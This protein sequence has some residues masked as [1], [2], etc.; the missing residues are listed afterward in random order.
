M[1]VA[2][3]MLVL[4]EE[5]Y[6]DHIICRRRVL[7]SALGLCIRRS[8]LSLATRSHEGNRGIRDLTRCPI[9]AELI[10]PPLG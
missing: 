2:V 10:I 5:V 8:I 7:K 9:T 3:N 6:K 1:N 4:L